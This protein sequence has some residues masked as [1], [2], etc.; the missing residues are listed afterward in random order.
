MAKF[1]ENKSLANISEFTV[2]SDVPL[3][4][5]TVSLNFTLCLKL[6]KYTFDQQKPSAYTGYILS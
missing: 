4:S 6:E 3:I 5:I 2:L 1:R